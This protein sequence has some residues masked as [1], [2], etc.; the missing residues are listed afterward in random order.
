MT[1]DFSVL[2]V[3]DP[4]PTLKVAKDSSVAMMR[5]L[6]ARGAQVWATT[7]PGLQWTE[8]QVRARAQ[9]LHLH[10]PKSPAEPWFEVRE[11]AVQPLASFGAVLMRKDPPFDS[12]YLY[13]THLLQAAQRQGARVFN[14]PRALREHNEKLAITEFAHLAPPTLVTRSHA[15]IVAFHAQ[16]GDVVLKPLDGMGGAEVFRLKPQ[17]HNLHVIVET[18]TRHGARTVMAQQ[19]LPAIAEGD[20][21]V[22]LIAGQAVPYALARIPQ[23]TETRGNLAVG[24]LARAQPLSDA[25]WRIANALGPTLAAR[26][27]LLVGLDVIGTH[28]TEINVTSPTCFVEIAAQTGCNVAALFVDALEATLGRK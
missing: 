19:Y 13:A 18:L 26:G 4:L 2:L 20:K 22:I 12:E 8:G 28:L 14:D 16:H 6:A 10:P 1:Q 21:R 11:D 15:D 3:V 24:G 9:R 17:E 25:D 23:G 5:E 27:L 7:L